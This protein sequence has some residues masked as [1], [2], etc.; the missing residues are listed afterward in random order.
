[1]QKKLRKDMERCS[2]GLEEQMETSSEFRAAGAENLKSFNVVLRAAWPLAAVAADWHSPQLIELLSNES[3]PFSLALAGATAR[4]SI[5]QCV[6]QQ[7][8]TVRNR[9]LLKTA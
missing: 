6:Q 7:D 8:I 3:G 5:S 4:K 2:A 1:M 9:E